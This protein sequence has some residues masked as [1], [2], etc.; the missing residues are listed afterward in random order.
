MNTSRE[1]LKLTS[2]GV[3]PGV[4]TGSQDVSR[5][6]TQCFP[7]HLPHIPLPNKLAP[8]ATAAHIAAARYLNAGI[9]GIALADHW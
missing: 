8:S 3:L 5:R 2:N 6:W 1:L 7:P 4:L 9:R